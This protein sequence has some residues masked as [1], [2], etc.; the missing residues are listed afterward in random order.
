MW[1]NPT[2]SEQEIISHFENER[3]AILNTIRWDIVD[4][5]NIQIAG[6][7]VF[8]PGAGIGDQTQLLLDRGASHVYVNDGRVDNLRLIE[9]RLGTEHLTFIHGNIEECLP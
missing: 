6:K 8:E 5:M 2:P 3:Y 4:G 7:S 9:E 1:N